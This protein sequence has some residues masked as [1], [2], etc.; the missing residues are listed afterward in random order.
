MRP[1]HTVPRWVSASQ[2]G[3]RPPEYVCLHLDERSLLIGSSAI[4][5]PGSGSG[6]GSSGITLTTSGSFSALACS[7]G[8]LLALFFSVG[9]AHPKQLVIPENCLQRDHS[10][11]ATVY[12]SLAGIA[13]HVSRG[14][15]IGC[16]CRTDRCAGRENCA[17]CVSRLAAMARIRSSSSSSPPEAQP[18]EECACCSS[19]FLG[20]SA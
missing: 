19:E 3:T 12:C 5:G 15:N 18:A 1:T 2:D 14:E 13:L 11:K 6:P 4:P 7:A 10:C 17:P 9:S 8:W 20:T 16:C